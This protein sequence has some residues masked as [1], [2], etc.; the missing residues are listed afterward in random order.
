MKIGIVAGEASGDIL[1]AD[2]I[3]SLKQRCF[4]TGCFDIKCVDAEFSGI[5]GQ[6]MIAEGF[7]SLYPQDRLAVMGLIEPLKLLPELIRIRQHLYDYFVSNGFDIVIGI[8]SP[9][10]NLALEKKLR[11]VGVKT[12]HY[13]SP[14]VWAWRQGRIKVIKKAVDLMLTLFPFEADFYH[15][16][17]VPVAFVGHPL[18]DQLSLEPKI[19]QARNIISGLVPQMQWLDDVKTIACLPGSRH[20]EVELIGP[21]IW[22]TINLLK[23]QYPEIQVIVPAL[24]EMRRQQIE[25]QLT[26]WS[27]LNIHV[28]DGHSQAV[29]AAADCIVM[30]SGTTT[31][32]AV[33]LKKPM[34]VVYK[35]AALSYAIIS[36]MLKVPYVSLPNLLSNRLLVPELLQDKATPQAIASELKRWFDHPELV[37]ELQGQFM[38]LHTQLRRGA[39]DRAADA[40]LQLLP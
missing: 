32:E 29:M 39:S 38:Q 37:T 15:Q 17:N 12:V 21:T 33:M 18:G 9:D 24:N 19:D 26:P 22:E 28:V 25:Q 27:D 36:R 1:G 13:V 11:K 5:G 35:K 30:A 20:G 31:L 34:V 40:I 4:E 2:L 8:D 16:H 6:L 3:R 7:Q 23:E 14:S 10:F